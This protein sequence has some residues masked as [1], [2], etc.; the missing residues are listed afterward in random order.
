MSQGEWL[1]QV[2]G[3]VNQMVKLRVRAAMGLCWLSLQFVC[4][5]SL[6]LLAVQP[7]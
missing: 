7:V 3:N 2:K 1:H 6:R 4:P 5:L